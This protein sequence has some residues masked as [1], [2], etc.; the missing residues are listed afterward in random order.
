MK[1]SPTLTAELVELVE[2]VAQRTRRARVT[3]TGT[4]MQ[5][6]LRAGMVVDIEPLTEPPH[7]GDILVFQS[8]TGLVAHRLVGGE[9]LKRSV[10][11]AVVADRLLDEK[12]RGFV[13]AGDARPDRAEIV[14][15]RLVVGR[16]R[17]VWA[18]AEPHAQRIDDTGYHRLGALLARTRALRSAFV[19]LRAYTTV[20]AALLLSDPVRNPR[21]RAFPA[22]VAA[23][24][25]FERCDYA[26]GVALLCSVPRTSMIE[27]ARRHHLSGFISGWLDAASE[28][29]VEAPA[30]L[31]VAFRQMR[32]AN[33]L[34]AGR[35]LM[36]VRDVRDRFS[37]ANIPHIFLKGGA[38]L[39]SDEPGADLQFSGD[40]DVIV[41]PDMADRAV[42]IL[43]NA[44]YRDIVSAERRAEYRSYD[45]HYEPLVLPR[46]AI[47]VEVHV[48]LA[49]T[50]VVSQNLD[51]TALEPSVRRIHGPV[52]EANVLDEVGAAV[53]LA[54]HARD[55]HVWRDIVLLSRLLRKLDR[56]SRTRFDAFMK[57]EKRDGLRLASAVNAA[58]A[59]AFGTSRSTQAVQ[60]YLAWAE[61]REGLPYRFGSPDIVEAVLGRCTVPKL[62]LHSRRNLARFLRRWIRNF[63]LLPFIARTALARR[64]QA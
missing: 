44:G 18:N 25:K 1:R 15:P 31:R 5:P 48:A 49:Q 56:A 7:I 43:R 64:L 12:T 59:I 21:S 4:S 61:L 3:I 36:C 50:A 53:H 54:Y 20:F 13:T 26:Q 30:D 10:L 37:A 45:H 39:A 23:T 17:A 35:V 29:G 51:Y 55:I 11:D 34:Q 2:L 63:A 33:A 42:A 62:R 24:H 60:R 41:P 32:L 40:V 52:G 47:P 6:L 9:I 14:S 46:I 19:K 38:R 8:Q 57:A 27:M 58:D 16:V 22:M 28:A